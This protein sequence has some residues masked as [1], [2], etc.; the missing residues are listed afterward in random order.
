[1]GWTNLPCDFF[2][3][4]DTPAHLSLLYLQ[5]RRRRR[6]RRHPRALSAVPQDTN[7]VDLAKDRNGLPI[8]PKLECEWEDCFP[9]RSDVLRDE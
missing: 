3:L 2:E 8:G 5:C 9:S 1:M 6:R 4:M 7:R